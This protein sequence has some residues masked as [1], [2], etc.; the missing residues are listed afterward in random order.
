MAD[1]L[2]ERIVRIEKVM[3]KSRR[4][5]FVGV[6]SKGGPSGDMITDHVVRIHTD[7]G[8]VGVGWSRINPKQA[9]QFLGKQLN[10]L[11]AL[12]KGCLEAGESIDLPL[13]DLVAKLSDLPLYKLL[14]AR[15]AGS[16]TLRRIGLYRRP[17]SG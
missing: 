12:P 13:W 11:F 7:S 2:D 5:R 16:G 10:E 4:P 3:L 8:A 6:N 15:L 9:E 17:K 14:G 1:L